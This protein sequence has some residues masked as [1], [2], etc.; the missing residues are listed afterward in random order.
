[1]NDVNVYVMLRNF[2][3]LLLLLKVCGKEVCTA[4][5]VICISSCLLFEHACVF[6]VFFFIMS[7]SALENVD[8]TVCSI[9]SWM[10]EGEQAIDAAIAAWYSTAITPAQDAKLR[11]LVLAAMGLSSQSDHVDGHLLQTG[12]GA[13]LCCCITEQCSTI[14]TPP[15]VGST[16][17]YV[18]QER[19]FDSRISRKAVG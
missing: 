19:G 17:Q 18:L 15:C 1:M 3:I 10:Q 7:V 4:A 5:Y 13:V 2:A 16:L 6:F 9:C 8:T 11:G 12:A 14:A